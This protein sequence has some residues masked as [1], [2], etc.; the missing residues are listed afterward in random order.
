[1]KYRRL[2]WEQACRFAAERRRLWA[3]AYDIDSQLLLLKKSEL[4]V[5]RQCRRCRKTSCLFPTAI[6]AVVGKLR[7]A[8][9]RRP[10]QDDPVTLQLYQTV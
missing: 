4:A 9:D 10:I 3:C 1:M 6:T 8:A 5:P 7:W 2:T